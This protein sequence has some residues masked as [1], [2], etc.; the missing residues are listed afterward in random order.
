[1]QIYCDE[2]YK[3]Q[4]VPNNNKDDW[5]EFVVRVLRRGEIVYSFTAHA[6]TVFTQIGDVI[7]WAKYN[8]IATGCSILAYDLKKRELLWTCD[9]IGNS[10][11]FHS[12]Y[13]NQVNIAQDGDLIVVYGK[14][15]NGR[16]IEYVDTK[17]GKTVGH[18]ALPW[19]E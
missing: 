17:S 19:K 3:V 13:R 2:P 14:E 11:W 6:E 12:K 18:K 15:S 7:Y 5:D 10:P 16:Y 8:R 4:I 9:L 1:L